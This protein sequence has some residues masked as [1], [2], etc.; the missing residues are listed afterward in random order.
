M[1]RAGGFKQ[2][3]PILQIS[4][5]T[6]AFPRSDPPTSL[7]GALTSALSDLHPKRISHNHLFIKIEPFVSLV[8]K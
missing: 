2:S 6:V 7:K 5:K 8:C 4:L 3:E 1:E